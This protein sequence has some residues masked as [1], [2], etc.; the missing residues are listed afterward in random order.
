MPKLTLMEE[1]LLLG[2]KDKQVRSSI[3]ICCSSL[4]YLSSPRTLSKSPF[5]PHFHDAQVAR[6]VEGFQ[7]RVARARTALR[8]CQS[9]HGIAEP[10]AQAV[11]QSRQLQRA[12]SGRVFGLGRRRRGSSSR[13]SCERIAADQQ[14][15]SL[16]TGLPLFLERQ[17]LLHP[18]RLH[19]YRARSPSP[20]RHGQGSQPETIPASRPVSFTYSLSYYPHR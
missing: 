15:L 16:E 5:K 17:H 10:P 7:Q 9:A 4:L 19:H 2:L 8:S 13:V 6:R 14:S 1:V 11:A 3:L 12:L 18:P 20:N